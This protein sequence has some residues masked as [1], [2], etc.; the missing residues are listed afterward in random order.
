VLNG[1]SMEIGASVVLARDR[2][3]YWVHCM[4][5]N[6]MHNYNYYYSIIGLAIVIG[7]II[8]KRLLCKTSNDEK[9]NYVC[10]H[11][12]EDLK[13]PPR[14]LHTIG[15]AWISFQKWDSLGL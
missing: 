9:E 5:K 10:S 1:K 11:M 15:L 13:N 3:S 2:P 4:F 6:E 7:I 8:M 14:P 12:G